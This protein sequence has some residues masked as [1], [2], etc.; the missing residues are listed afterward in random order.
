VPTTGAPSNGPTGAPTEPTVAPTGAPTAPTTAP[1]A[2]PTRVS[3]TATPTP[4]PTDKPTSMPTATPTTAMPTSSPST[5]PSFLPTTAPTMIPTDMPSRGGCSV[6]LHGLWYH[7]CA[8]DYERTFGEYDGRPVYRLVLDTSTVSAPNVAT[9]TSGLYSA[10]YLFFHADILG[11]SMW[12]VSDMPGTTDRTHWMYFTGLNVDQYKGTSRYPLSGDTA[13]ETRFSAPVFPEELMGQYHDITCWRVLVDDEIAMKKLT[14]PATKPFFRSLPPNQVQISCVILAP[15]APPTYSPTTSPTVAPSRTPSFVPSLSPTYAP[16]AAPTVPTLTPSLAPTSQP[17]FAP[18]AAPSKPT[19]APTPAPT[20]PPSVSPTSPSPAPTAVPTTIPTSAVPTTAPTDVPTSPTVAPTALPTEVPTYYDELAHSG[21]VCTDTC[22]WWTNDGHCDDGGP[23]SRSALCPRGSDCTD[24]GTSSRLGSRKQ[25][26]TKC[27]PKAAPA[28]GMPFASS[29]AAFLGK[30][31]EASKVGAV[32]GGLGL[33]D[34]DAGDKRPRFSVDA[35]VAFETVMKEMREEQENN[36]QGKGSADAGRKNRADGSD[37]WSHLCERLRLSVTNGTAAVSPGASVD[38]TVGDK[39][40]IKSAL[41]MGMGMGAAIMS[42]FAGVYTLQ[43]AAASSSPMLLHGR[44][45]YAMNQDGHLGLA[46]SQIPP[47]PPCQ[48]HAPAGGMCHPSWHCATCK[49]GAAGPSDCLS[50]AAGFVLTG[51]DWQ[52]DC[53]ATCNPGL[54]AG[55]SRAKLYLYYSP[56]A[57]SWAGSWKVAPTLGTGQPWAFAQ[58]QALSAEQIDMHFVGLPEVHSSGSAVGLPGAKW[59][60]DTKAFGKGKSSGDSGGMGWMAVD[61]EAQGHTDS[62]STASWG[63]RLQCTG[64]PAFEL[65][66]GLYIVLEVH[67]ESALEFSRGH[68][69]QAMTK[70]VAAV[71]GVRWDAVA[72]VAVTEIDGAAGAAWQYTNGVAKAGG[73][74]RLRRRLGSSRLV[75]SNIDGEDEWA[76]RPD[77]DGGPDAASLLNSESLKTR[78]RTSI[79]IVFEVALY[80]QADGPRLRKR[81]AVY[82]F[83]QQLGAVVSYFAPLFLFHICTLT[84]TP[85]LSLCSGGEDWLRANSI[86]TASRIHDQ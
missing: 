48:Q 27:K 31:N 14:P 52:E 25:P 38:V 20:S 51:V 41:G 37:G 65:R 49:A 10:R 29:A 22:T 60:A 6:H 72:V 62:L 53:T 82:G 58:T 71:S 39:K 86:W 5:Q 74:H 2:T 77:A 75:R 26:H 32:P 83:G 35:G 40:A 85:T 73:R 59:F 8:G 30:S 46:S 63:V 79:E 55:S 78:A 45:V 47:H 7:S 18:T 43:L 70:G 69:R 1:T 28:A 50:C 11:G 42:L 4:A 9:G 44:P 21:C 54:V 66:A 15:T 61:A 16:S 34:E 80:N 76:S 64:A 23:G 36:A 67:G 33:A 3:P 81:V 13:T 24:C 68:R 57:T 84:P 17:T 19:E 12:V 56:G